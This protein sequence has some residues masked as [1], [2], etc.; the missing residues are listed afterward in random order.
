MFPGLIA[1]LRGF[2]APVARITHHVVLHCTH[3]RHQSAANSSLPKLQSPRSP[4]TLRSVCHKQAAEQP[5]CASTEREKER[6]GRK[7]FR[8]GRVTC[9]PGGSS[10]RCPVYRVSP[11]HTQTSPEMRRVLHRKAFSAPGLTRVQNGTVLGCVFPGSG[12]HHPL[13]STPVRTYE[14]HTE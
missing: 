10:C 5:P 12:A 7:R 1:Y 2:Q 11:P 14:E 6:R 13:T 9:S 3:E 4:A 8:V